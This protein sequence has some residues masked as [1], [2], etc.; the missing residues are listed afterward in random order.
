[1]TQIGQSTAAVK[2]YGRLF[3]DNSPVDL[4]I[5]PINLDVYPNMD[6]ATSSF[7]SEDSSEKEFPIFS[8]T[9]EELSLLSSKVYEP[10]KNLCVVEIPLKYEVCVKDS[11]GM[12]DIHVQSLESSS[13]EVVTQSGNITSKSLKGDVIQ[14]T[15][16]SGN[17][18]CQGVTQGNITFQSESGDIHGHRFQ[19]PNL[20]IKT[21]TGNI[22]TESIYSDVSR[23]SS[24]KGNINLKNLHRQCYVTI[25]DNGNLTISGMDGSLDAVLGD[26]VHQIQ[27][28]QLQ[29]LSS[30]KLENGQLT[31]KIPEQCPF[32]IRI[33]AKSLT[34]PEV[35]KE[36]ATK[37]NDEYTVL[38]YNQEQSST[39]DINAENS[40]VVVQFEDWLASL[41]FNWK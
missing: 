2:H 41:G 33:R 10:L 6:V 36:V 38:E 11:L 34:L 4:T 24:Q 28:S 37:H 31:L 26:G 9:A 27:I 22:S 3:L 40:Q 15:S 32:G 20:E 25:S 19:G 1:L 23:F 35:M 39:I 29:G 5:K 21:A 13:I 8:Q 14:L 16:Q 7:F 18:N 30:I 12:N 17:I